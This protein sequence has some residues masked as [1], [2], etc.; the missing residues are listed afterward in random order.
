MS[1]YHSLL[2]TI[3]NYTLQCCKL[4]GHFCTTD[5]CT[6][7]VIDTGCGQGPQL[8]LSARTVC[9]RLWPL[10]VAWASW[11]RGRWIPRARISRESS[12]R[13]LRRLLIPDLRTHAASR[14]THSIHQKKILRSV[15]G[16]R[17]RNYTYPFGWG[18]CQRICRLIFKQY[19]MAIKESTKLHKKQQSDV[20]VQTMRAMKKRP[21]FCREK[22][23]ILLLLTKYFF[24]CLQVWF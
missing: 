5:L 7:L 4:Y 8:K 15:P 23:G 14:P 21:S 22:Q 13:K 2:I 10:R 19:E 24:L 18:N 20:S 6:Y 16:Q 3:I 12:P 9:E 17:E 1:E 11:Q